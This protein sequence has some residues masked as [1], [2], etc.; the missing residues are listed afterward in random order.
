MVSHEAYYFIGL[1]YIYFGAAAIAA[2]NSVI[3]GDDKDVA[4]SIGVVTLFGTLFMFLYPLSFLIFKM[5]EL[6][7]LL[8]VGTSIHE[9]AQVV[10]AGFAISQDVGA[11][12]T[13]VK[14]IR[15]LLIIPVTLLLAYSS[16]SIGDGTKPNWRGITIP[17]FVIMFLAVVVINSYVGMPHQ[18]RNIL[19]DID[20]WL[21]TVA[22]AALGLGI[23]LVDVRKM[24]VR[25]LFLGLV[26]SVFIS[27]FSILAIVAFR[28]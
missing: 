17:W 11:E 7:Y 1:W 19:I 21:M 3:K 27:G 18:V 9:V 25:P 22:M 2:V 15:V 5:N 4:Y 26:S 12:A 6:V 13:M 16:N 24:G 23:K 28:G 20:G 8:W 14:L 10:A